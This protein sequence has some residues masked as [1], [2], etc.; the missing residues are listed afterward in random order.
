MT[1]GQNTPA[2]GR[3]I[4]GDPA[5]SIN[6]PKLVEALGVK[7][8]R[9]RQVDPYEL[10][11]LFK[12]LREETKINEPSV[13]IASRPCVLIEDFVARPPL[14]V[15]EDKCTGC[16]TCIDVGCPAILVTCLLYTSPYSLFP[17]AIFAAAQPAFRRH[18]SA[19]HPA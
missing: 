6:F 7:P 15:I 13:I 16:G 2:N 1:G 8:V 5:P 4:H 9:I 3:D 18:R 11:V 17:S 19:L 14:T 12:T 10:P